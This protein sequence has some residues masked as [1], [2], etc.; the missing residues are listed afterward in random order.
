MISDETIR[1]LGFDLTVRFCSRKDNGKSQVKQAMLSATKSDSKLDQN[2]TGGKIYAPVLISQGTLDSFIA[3]NPTNS[4]GGNAI[5][6]YFNY[7]GANPD[8][9]DHF[10]L[11]GNNTFGVEDLYGGGDRD[12]NDL[13][14]N[15]NV[16]TP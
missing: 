2:L 3:N 6:A 10:R 5:H 1:I 14:I 8:K 15:L 12:F 16:K 4:G 9:V 13:V 7:V 11:I